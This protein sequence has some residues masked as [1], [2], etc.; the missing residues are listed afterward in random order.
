MNRSVHR[1]GS[2]GPS[3]HAEA[4]SLFRLI[5]SNGETADTLRE[6]IA[7]PPRELSILQA[8]TKRSP[9]LSCRVERAI[10]FRQ[11]VLEEFDRLVAKN[12]PLRHAQN[13]EAPSS[14]HPIARRNL[15]SRVGPTFDDY[16]RGKVRVLGRSGNLPP[17]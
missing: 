16:P 5:G 7:I 3:A 4:G 13:P 1:T 12:V 9:E 11:Q 15:R 8:L 2:P 17:L 14:V 6:L 10:E